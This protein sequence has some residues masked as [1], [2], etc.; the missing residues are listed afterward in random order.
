MSNVKRISLDVNNM[1]ADILGMQYGVDPAAIDALAPYA[2]A[3]QQNV[4]R[5]RGKGMLGW[6][7]LP[8]NQAEILGHMDAVAEKVRARFDAFVVLGIGGSALGPIAVQQ[9]LNHLR[10]NELP[11]EKRNGPKLYVEDNIDPERMASLLDVIDVKKTCFNIITKSG[12][13]AETMSQYLIISELLKREVGEGWQEHIIATTDKSRGNLIQLARAEGFEMFVIPDG[14]GGRFSEMSPVGLLAAAVCGIDIHAML[15]GAK[16][17][18]EAC[19]SGDVWKNPAL[20]EAALQYVCM[21]DMDANIQVMLP[22]ADSLK[23]IADWFCQLWAESLGKNVTRKGM[24]VNVGQTPVKALGVT[25][26]HS[27]L[28]LYTEGPYDKVV[29][30]FKVEKFRAET[31]I[32]HGCEQFPDVAFLGGKTHGQLIEAERQGTEYALYRAGRMNQTIIL[33]EV[34]A[35]TVG[36]LLF[37][38]EL[39]TAYAGELLDIDAFNQPGVEESKLASF[40]VLG[41]EAE[42]FAKKREEMAACPP[43]KGQYTV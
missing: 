21:T 29:T 14:V 2:A 12:A 1:M 34:N 37:F 43:R 42:K 32:P 35:H 33:P 10:W 5:N 11:A 27:Q 18:D 39:V 6:T 40:A 24:A 4:A 19:Q 3:A 38:F 9:A 16:C 15:E 36:Q 26:Q 28:Q 17:M 22:Y 20:L 25:D 30:F 23:S 13:T 8:Y 7:E 41:H 31:P